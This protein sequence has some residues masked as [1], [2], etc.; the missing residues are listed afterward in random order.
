MLSEQGSSHLGIAQPVEAL[1][2][3]ER[4]Q[5]AIRRAE[6]EWVGR[7][8]QPDQHADGAH[9]H[10]RLDVGAGGVPPVDCVEQFTESVR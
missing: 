4:V 2:V 10:L 5:L 1:G 8:L 7:R 9:R 6:H 3:I